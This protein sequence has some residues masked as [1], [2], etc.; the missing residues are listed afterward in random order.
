MRNRYSLNLENIPIKSVS[1]VFSLRISYL[2]LLPLLKMFSCIHC[3]PITQYL[4]YECFRFCEVEPFPHIPAGAVSCGHS[5]ASLQPSASHQHWNPNGHTRLVHNRDSALPL[6]RLVH[7][8]KAP[9][10]SPLAAIHPIYS[11]VPPR[12]CWRNYLNLLCTAC[13]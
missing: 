5:V 10:Y 3:L 6:L 1:A 4:N 7:G 2:V 11:P 8:G 12:C 13:H 9:L